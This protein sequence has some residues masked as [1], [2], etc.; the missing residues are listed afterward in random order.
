MM[1]PAEQVNV[2]LS[3]IEDYRRE[4]KRLQEVIDSCKEATSDYYN[5]NNA[6]FMENV[7]LK[8]KV[9]GLLDE[10]YSLEVE[11][12]NYE[13]DN[14][15]YES[16]IAELESEIATLKNV[17]DDLNGKLDEYYNENEEEFK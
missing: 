13:R 1:T 15:E 6:L 16:E 10:N 9:E 11:L 4:N 2:F 8:D 17:I 12:R 5:E 7:N 3:I 14:L